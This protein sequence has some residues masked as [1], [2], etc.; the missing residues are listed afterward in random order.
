MSRNISS[1]KA[2]V[3]LVESGIIPQS[4][5]TEFYQPHQEL[6]DEE[7][8]VTAIED[9]LNHPSRSQLLASYKE[10]LKS[11]L[12]KSNWNACAV[13]PHKSP[14]IPARLYILNYPTKNQEKIHKY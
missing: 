5:V 4:E 7:E 2:F 14:R 1:V 8:I 3:E 13:F 11:L 6:E 9:W 10:K 12:S